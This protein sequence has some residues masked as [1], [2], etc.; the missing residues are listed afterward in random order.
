MRTL[1]VLCWLL[2]IVDMV[3]TFLERVGFSFCLGVDFHFLNEMGLQVLKN[4][5][6]SYGG[7]KEY[8]SSAAGLF[9]LLGKIDFKPKT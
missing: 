9:C 1:V 6:D 4:N 3:P 7:C 5:S 8:Q 2:G